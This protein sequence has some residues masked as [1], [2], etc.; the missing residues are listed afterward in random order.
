MTAS[1]VANLDVESRLEYLDRYVGP[2]QPGLIGVRPP[3]V[4]APTP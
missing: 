4:P 1:V 2:A 3:E